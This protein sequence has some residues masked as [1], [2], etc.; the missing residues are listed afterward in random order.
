ML[1]SATLRAR[2]QRLSP[3]ALAAVAVL[4]ASGCLDLDPPHE[5][6]DSEP[7]AHSAEA[8]EQARPKREATVPAEGWNDDIAWRGLEEGLEEAKR[9][10]RPIMMVVHTSWCSKCRAL[11]QAFNSEADIET[12]SEDFVMVHADQDVVPEAALYAPDGTYIPRVMFLDSSGNVDR[13]LQNPGRTDKFRYF[14]SPQE[15]LVGT[16][17]KALNRHGNKT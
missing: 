3:L 5:R 13:E 14:Y 11:K 2:L 16:M 8:P 15:D 9:T 1:F 7:A 10:D 17:R 4:S 6:G 12:L